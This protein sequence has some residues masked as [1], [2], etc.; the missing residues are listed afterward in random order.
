MIRVRLAVRGA[1]AVALVGCCAAGAAAQAPPLDPPVATPVGQASLKIGGEAR[2][3]FEGRTPSDEEDGFEWDALTAP[4]L[5]LWRRRVRVWGALEFHRLATVHVEAQ[6]AAVWSSDAHRFPEFDR[7]DLRQAHL[8]VRPPALR[9]VTLRVGRFAVPT[10]GDGRLLSEDDFADVG[11]ALDGMAARIER[12]PVRVTALVANVPEVVS[13]PDRPGEGPDHWLAAGIVEARP[14]GW[15]ELDWVHAERWFPRD[16]A[17][18]DP[19]DQRTGPRLDA[20]LGGRAAVRVGPV[21]LTAEAYAQAGVVGPDPLLAAATAERVD[22]RVWDVALAP[23]VFLEHAFAS[24]DRNPT[25]GVRETFD[26]LFPDTH[27]HLG[28][29]DAVGWRNINALAT[30]LTVSLAPLARALADWR[31]T[32]VARGSFLHRRADAWYGADGQPRLVDST[33]SAASSHT[34]EGELSGWVEGTLFEGRAAVSL[35]LAHWCPNNWLDDLGY[36]LHGYR[37]WAQTSVRF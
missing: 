35:G 16:F 23:T 15:L 6:H 4:A 31:L 10:V 12:G 32:F 2:V 8:E 25:D 34:L 18:E 30:G 27:A 36:E 1:A 22:W 26:P 3:R 28:P 11:R 29:Y 21:R 19:A 9:G 5:R 20:T 17:S 13:L 14:A 37:V 24:G 33:G 7:V